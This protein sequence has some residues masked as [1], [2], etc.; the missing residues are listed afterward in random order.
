MTRLTRP[1]LLDVA[2][3]AIATGVQVALAMVLS[4][5]LVNID[6]TTGKTILLSAI[7][8]AL[9]V[10]KGVA[11]SVYPAGDGTASMLR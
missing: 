8:A 7:A 3:R 1:Q 11:A 5:G 4:T 9:S 6:A 10:I 2:E